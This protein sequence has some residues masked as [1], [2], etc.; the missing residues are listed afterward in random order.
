MAED[1]TGELD[2]DS[3]VTFTVLTKSLRVSWSLEEK[4]AIGLPPRPPKPHSGCKVER[5]I[6]EEFCG[7]AVQE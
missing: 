7:M 1:Q 6:A 5:R 3:G 4:D 2:K